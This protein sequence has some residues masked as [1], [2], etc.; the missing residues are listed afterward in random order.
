SMIGI[1]YWLEKK[2]MSG[3]FAQGLLLA[4]LAALS[5]IY[6]NPFA[7]LGLWRALPLFL[8]ILAAALFHRLRAQARRPECAGYDKNLTAF[9][10]VL[11]S[12]LLMLKILLFARTSHY[13]FAL[14]LPATLAAIVA[15]I[16]WIPNFARTH[17]GDG[18]LLRLLALGVR[19]LEASA[20]VRISDAFYRQK[21]YGV[22]QGADTFQAD[23]RARAAE[24]CLGLARQEIGPGQKFCVFPEGIMLNYLAR[25]PSSSLYL[26]FVPVDITIFGEPAMV[27]GLSQH[28]PDALFVISRNDLDYGR[29]GFGIDYGLS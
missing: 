9:C 23:E 16:D 15:L 11:G 10:F 14:A 1:F 25:R 19:A 5:L 3:A 2:K 28:P 22:G 8:L 18:R 24:L 26:S 20:H 21:T 6:R 29:R 12:F 7:W 13:G 4:G 27:R 17:G